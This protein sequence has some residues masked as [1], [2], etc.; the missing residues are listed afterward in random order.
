MFKTK[1]DGRQAVR[2]TT[3]AFS[4]REGGRLYVAK[5][6][7]LVVR[8]CRPLP[9][10]PSSVTVSRD[11]ADRYWASFV[12]DVEPDPLPAIDVEC[13]IDLRLTYF[14]VL[15]DGS[16]IASPRFLRRAE[17]KLKQAQRELSRKQ[18]GSANWR[19]ARKRV[20]RQH[21]KVAD[22][23]RDWHHQ[24]STRIIRENQAV[25]VEDLAVAAL[26]RSRLAK[27]VRDAGWTRFVDMLE[28]KARRY[29]REFR[30]VHRFAPT[31]RL[32]STCGA[33]GER[34]GLNVRDWTCRSCG[35]RHDR[36]VNAARNIL[37]LG[38]RE[39]LNACREDVRPEHALAIFNEAG[40][41][42]SEGERK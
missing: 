18:K 42:R 15:S 22:R 3:N 27:S 1:R 7:E 16:K 20:A 11:A 30:K 28:Y 14:A 10:V 13:G 36:D 38:R 19:K 21:A 6:G 39:R 2:L 31:T 40:T 35:M 33:C 9:S 41:D 29:G 32:C 25:Y 34:L 37:A 5:V 24:A 26:A 8:W 12:V 17:R 4:I 23:R